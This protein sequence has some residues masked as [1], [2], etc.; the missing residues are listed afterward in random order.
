MLIRL[1][2]SKSPSHSNKYGSTRIPILGN[3]IPIAAE[4]RTDKHK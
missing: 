1:N 4:N 3:D 2:N